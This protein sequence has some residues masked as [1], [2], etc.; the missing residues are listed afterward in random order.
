MVAVKDPKVFDA[1]GYRIV[2]G[3]S[4]KLL[5]HKDPALHHPVGGL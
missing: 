1:P 2:E 3:V 4:P 5:R